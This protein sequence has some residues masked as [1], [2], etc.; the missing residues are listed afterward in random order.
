MSLLGFAAVF[1]SVDA[2]A[3][4]KSQP[5]TK[6]EEVLRCEI[7][8]GI[9]FVLGS[10]KTVNCE[11]HKNGAK[12]ERYTGTL[13]KL[14][15]DIGITQKSYLAW[16]VGRLGNAAREDYS[17]TGDY[18]G[19][20]ADAALGV[21]LGA[22]ALLGG[23]RKNVVLQPFSTEEMHGVNIAIGVSRLRRRLIN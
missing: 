8:G 15:L 19:I 16:S 14:G 5:V 9:G 17:L 6:G 21:G 13:G 4:T 2:H 11:F 18:E 10:S 22:N 20:S 23:D 12:I 3:V 1:C 7:E